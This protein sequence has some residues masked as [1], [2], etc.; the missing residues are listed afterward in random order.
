MG[1]FL[2]RIADVR[3]FNPL[4]FFAY[5]FCSEIHISFEK[6]CDNF[7]SGVTISQA[8]DA[9]A[10]AV[11]NRRSREIKSVHKLLWFRFFVLSLHT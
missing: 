6:G 7:A 4:I 5:I 9:V 11:K 2:T 8:L 10:A 1:T 3:L